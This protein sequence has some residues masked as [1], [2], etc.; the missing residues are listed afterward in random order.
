MLECVHTLL[1]TIKSSSRHEVTHLVTN[2]SL[3][4]CSIYP[5]VST[6]ASAERRMKQVVSKVKQNIKHTVQHTILR[7]RNITYMVLGALVNRLNIALHL[8]DLWSTRRKTA[9]WSE[10]D[11]VT[12][13]NEAV[14]VS[15]SFKKAWKRQP[16]YSIMFFSCFILQVDY[17]L[18]SCTHWAPL[19]DLSRT[20]LRTPFP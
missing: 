3:S 1:T 19:R 6:A 9:L 7:S 16:G 8:K 12:N 2:H 11:E 18:F 5:Q 4:A 14:T 17:S 13:A 10:E 20:D 15:K